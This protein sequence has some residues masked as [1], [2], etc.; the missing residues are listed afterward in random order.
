MIQLQ[1]VRGADIASSVIAWFSQGNFSHVDAVL[2]DGNLLGA[3]NDSVGGRPPGVQIRPPDYAPFPVK[4]RMDI[5][6]TSPQ[7]AAFYAFLD[8]QLGKPYD[9]EAIW[10]FAAGRN[11]RETD[12]WICS[13]VISAAGESAVIFPPLYLAANKIT[14]VACALA[15][16]AVG[17][18]VIGD[19]H[20]PR[21][22]QEHGNGDSRYVR[23][24]YR[25]H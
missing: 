9:T 6:S 5:P 20:A 15:F 23:S 8:E 18:A 1:F 10:A 11:W 25:N 22:D 7:E 16:S 3:R 19:A 17:G 12:S 14:P 4:V 24:R 21:I 13:E 2:S